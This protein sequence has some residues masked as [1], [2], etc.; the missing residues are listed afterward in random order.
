[1]FLNQTTSFKIFHQNKV[2]NILALLAIVVFSRLQ[3]LK[4]MAVS[5]E[6]AWLQNMHNTIVDEFYLRF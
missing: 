3:R 4:A 5:E 1:M 2:K 6:T